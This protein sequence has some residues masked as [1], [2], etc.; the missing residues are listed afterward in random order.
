MVIAVKAH[1]LAYMALPKAGC[2][3]VKEAL[4]RLDPDVTVPPENDI[5]VHTWHALYPTRRFRRH[6]WRK[7]ADHWRFCVVRD[8]L[9]RLLSVYTNR[10]LG[11]GDTY[12]SRKIK[13]GRPW[14]PDLPREPDPDTFF[15]NLDAYCLGSSS[16]KHHTV[17]AWLFLGPSLDGYNRVYRT[18]EMADLA[19]DLGLLT[20][21]PVTMPRGNPSQTR[22]TLDD[23][24]GETID[25][26][27][28]FLEQEY[29]YLEGYY[30]NP[31]GPRLHDACVT[32]ARR[33]S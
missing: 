23:L 3:S 33:V 17:G 9:K 10:V 22:L 25:A 5:D 6:R 4:A 29:A 26:I 32:S 31:L 16:I 28:P 21:Q 11:F 30:A 15:R 7:Y 24:K 8:P 12:N 14:L 2:S 13:N 27:R 20:R 19:W 18:E 1:K